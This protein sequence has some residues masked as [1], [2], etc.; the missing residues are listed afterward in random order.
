M[1]EPYRSEGQI[2]KDLEASRIGMLVGT[3]LKNQ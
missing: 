2:W 3:F 1:R